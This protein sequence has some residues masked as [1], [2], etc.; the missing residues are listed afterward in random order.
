MKLGEKPDRLLF[1]GVTK[2]ANALQIG[3]GAAFERG[4]RQTHADPDLH[5]GFFKKKMAIILCRL[6]DLVR[7]GRSGFQGG[8]HAQDQDEVMAGQTDVGLLKQKGMHAKQRGGM[9]HFTDAGLCVPG[10]AWKFNG[11]KDGGRKRQ[12]ALPQLFQGLCAPGFLPDGH[13]QNWM[14]NLIGDQRELIAQLLLNAPGLAELINR[15]HA[16]LDGG[17]QFTVLLGLEDKGV[18]PVVDRRF[19]V[20]GV[21]IGGENNNLILK[22]AFPQVSQSFEA[23]DARHIDIHDDD[24]SGRARDVLQNL[25]LDEPTSALTNAEAEKL[26]V[27]LHR[28]KAQG[29]AIILISHKMDE[30]FENADRI[31]VLRDGQTINSHLTSE[32]ERSTIITEMVGRELKN[33]YPAKDYTPSDEILLR[34]EH[35]TVEH[36]FATERNIVEDFSFHLRRGEILGFAGLVGAGRSELVNALFGKTQKIAGELELE[37]KPLKIREPYDAVSAGLA[38]VTENRKEDGFVGPMSIQRNI[39]LA[40]FH[41]IAKGFHVSAKLERGYARKYFD[42]LSIRA[43]S[44]NTFVETLSGGNQQKVIVGKWLMA[45]PKV[46]ILDEPTK[47]IDVTTKAAIYQLMV[48]L[49]KQGISIIMISSEMPELVAMSDRVIVFNAGHKAAE[50]TGDE[51]NQYRIMEY[52][53]MNFS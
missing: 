45:D 6:V 17:F 8:I 1:G 21:V 12:L 20:V 18:C 36:P 32:V 30:V 9:G 7:I 25:I 15:A 53:T 37:G 14:Q 26:F 4:L 46:L 3:F 52:A 47:G 41:K 23:V 40:G 49:V 35:Y 34:A 24:V 27:L 16:V 22:A 42:A 44:L 50:L 38:L 51:I 31:T 29:M 19:E 48:D 2:R 43:P 39:C 10:A 28:L 5:P 13:T 33:F 11:E